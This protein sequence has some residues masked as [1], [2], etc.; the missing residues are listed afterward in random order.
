MV[1]IS[2]VFT[3]TG[4]AKFKGVSR[5][6]IYAMIDS[7]IIKSENVYPVVGGTLIVH[8]EKGVVTD[9]APIKETPV[10]EKPIQ[11]TQPTKQPIDFDFG[12]LDEDGDE[13]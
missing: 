13:F 5:Q 3:P 2:N 1:D 8:E 9:K 7:G 11:K 4:Y 10:V 6:R 12:I